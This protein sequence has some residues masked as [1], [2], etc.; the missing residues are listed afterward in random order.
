MEAKLKT[1]A[2]QAQVKDLEL[3]SQLQAVAALEAQLK[4]AEATAN[5]QL[6][7]AVDALQAVSK[8]HSDALATLELQL[9]VAR[10]GTSSAA[11][12]LN[13]KQTEN[14]VLN[15]KVAALEATVAELQTQLA[16]R[17]VKDSELIAKM[18]ANKDGTVNGSEVEMHVLQME[19]A[20]AADKTRILNLVAELAE[21]KSKVGIAEGQLAKAAEDTEA[22]SKE[23]SDALAVLEQQLMAADASEHRTETE[24]T[25][26][27]L[28]DD[29]ATRETS[30]VEAR[31]SITELERAIEG[32]EF[33]N[34][35]NATKTEKSDQTIQKLTEDATAGEV[36]T[37]QS[38]ARVAEL[39]QLLATA[40]ANTETGKQAAEESDQRAQDQVSGLK[41][42]VTEAEARVAELEQMLVVNE[43]T[44]ESSDTQVK[45]EQQQVIEHTMDSCT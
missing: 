35:V 18:D 15:G 3:T 34:G 17:T 33:A 5:G 43:T 25:I 1:A 44:L 32:Y 22:V 36:A 9:E 23:E 21:L 37:A 20:K 10:G 27:Q 13:E 4:A 8:E 41:A 14:A 12:A 6:A 11:S 42:A 24:Q 40:N 29:A 45:D 28:K 30:V 7:K 2:E 19:Q 38:E 26:Q 31:A 16:D 39:E